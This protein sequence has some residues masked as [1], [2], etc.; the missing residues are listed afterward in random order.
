MKVAFSG[1]HWAEPWI[2]HCSVPLILPGENRADPFRVWL[3]ESR[4]KGLKRGCWCCCYVARD[5]PCQGRTMFNNI[6]LGV[7]GKETKD[8]IFFYTKASQK[9]LYRI[10]CVF[11]L[12]V[13]RTHTKCKCDIFLLDIHSVSYR[14][15]I[16]PVHRSDILRQ[17]NLELEQVNI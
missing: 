11:S 14:C 17:P 1:H 2:K 3:T 5:H 6:C 13:G 4:G 8:N 15:L 10:D 9:D 12:K 16:I 7:S